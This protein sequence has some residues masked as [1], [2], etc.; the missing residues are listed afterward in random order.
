M[1]TTQRLEVQ[2]VQNEPQ[3]RLARSM[4]RQRRAAPLRREVLQQRLNEIEQVVHLLELAARVLVQLSF[5]GQDVQFLQQLNGLARTQF[6]H[7]R[8]IS[9][10][11]LRRYMRGR[12]SRFHSRTV[13]LAW[14]IHAFSP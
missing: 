1:P 5:S 4:V 3:V 8:S 7:H 11:L 2:V 13:G 10:A 14:S 6:L 12:L 9:A